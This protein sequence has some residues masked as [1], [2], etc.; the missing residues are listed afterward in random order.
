MQFRKDINGLR[1]LAVIGVVLFHFNAAWLPGGFAG[2]DVFFVISGFLM[3]GIIFKGIEQ[4]NFSIA[5]FY[6]ARANR[7]IPALALLCFLMLLFGWLYLPPLDYQLLGKHA[8]SSI[9]FLSNI[10][11]W[12]EAGYFDAASH[13]KWL[14]HTWSL[15]VEWQFYIIYPLVL[16]F[17]HKFTTIKLMNYLIVAATFLGFVFCVFASFNWPNAAYYLLPTRAWEMMIGGVAYLF[18]IVVSN[19]KKMLLERLGLA[20]IVGSYFIVTKEDAW[21]GYAALFPV[22]GAFFVILAARDKSFITGNVFFQKIGAWSYSIYLWHWPLVVGIYYYTLDDKYIYLG[23]ALSVFLGFL[24]NKYIEQIKF[25]KDFSKIKDYLKCKPI[26]IA[27]GLVTLSLIIFGKTRYFY[28]MPDDIY[29][30]VTVTSTTNNSDYTFDKLRELEDKTTFRDVKYK[31]LIIGDSQSGDFV[32]SLCETGL[33]NNVD[34]ISRIVA[35][36]CQV[37][38]LDEEMLNRSFKVNDNISNGNISNE[39]CQKQI[40]TIQADEALDKAD[41]IVVSMFWKDQSLPYVFKSI[42]NIRS[43]NKS[44]KIYVVGGKSFNRSA[45]DII[46]E[47]YYENTDISAAA[48]KEISS[49]D[50]AK[51]DF[52][53]S[54][55]IKYQKV[56]NFNFINIMDFFCSSGECT[57]LG[58]KNEPLYFDDTHITEFGAKYLGTKIKESNYFPND[59]YQ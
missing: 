58:S 55:F 45:Q 35:A 44:A 47:S 15:S 50:S 19:K 34:V 29:K 46:Y 17:I 53:K 52:Q 1:A 39:R 30:A 11:Y 9:S 27:L 12:T 37:F 57:I 16:V 42:E 24:S 4:K 36:R 21:P 54:E 14:L 6:V 28:N 5:H 31:L 7:I 25:K 56:L 41:V 49:N 43:R 38:A 48:Y 59:F 23:I 51:I 26:Y 20:L 13:E 22:L 33:S 18:P 40:S 32:N 8:L 3:T 2:V 10:T